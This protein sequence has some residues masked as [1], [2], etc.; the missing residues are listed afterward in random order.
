MRAGNRCETPEGGEAPRLL[1]TNNHRHATGHFRTRNGPLEEHQSTGASSFQR[2]G[3]AMDVPQQEVIRTV[4]K[5]A[6]L[7]AFS[8]IFLHEQMQ[9]DMSSKGFLPF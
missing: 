8:R 3:L 2:P 1:S 4:R 5:C 7:P 9:C 6:C